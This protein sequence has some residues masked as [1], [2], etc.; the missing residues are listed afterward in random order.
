M[1]APSNS[2]A[3]GPDYSCPA[4]R[5]RVYATHTRDFTGPNAAAITKRLGICTEDIYWEIVESFLPYD[6]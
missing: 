2:A 5:A 6:V 3:F 1:P 4:F